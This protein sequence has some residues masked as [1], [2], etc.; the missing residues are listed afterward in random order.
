MKTLGKVMMAMAVMPLVVAMPVAAQEMGMGMMGGGPRMVPMMGG[1]VMLT[2]SAEA[3]RTVKQDHLQ[4]TMA[5]EMDGKDAPAVQNTINRKMQDAQKIYAK[6]KDVKVNTGNYS[7]WQ[8]YSAE[9]VVE[10]GKVTSNQQKNGWHGS[11]QL[12]LQGDVGS[13]LLKLMGELQNLGFV[14]QGMNYSLSTEEAE[15]LTDELTQEALA[16]ITARAK[17]IGAALDMGNVDYVS[18]NTTSGGGM[19]RPVPMMAMAKFGGAADMATPV[20]Q[21][22]ESEV[23][24]SVDAT[25]R[26]K[27]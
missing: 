1:G 12:V 23:T 17:K 3:R 14:A 27:K 20:G 24:V 11:Q 18:I 15:K 26:L 10:N 7:V 13:N 4:T 6:Y 9:T 2:L 5:F 16:K 22:G 21:A 8:Q 25:V 19:Q